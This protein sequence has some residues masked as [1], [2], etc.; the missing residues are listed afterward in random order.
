MNHP[1]YVNVLNKLLI[2]YEIRSKFFL[3]EPLLKEANNL[4]QTWLLK[5]TTFLS[6]Q[7]LANYTFMVQEEGSELNAFLLA[8]HF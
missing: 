1:N 6:E 4:S 5:A 3:A 8:R 7:E 2:N